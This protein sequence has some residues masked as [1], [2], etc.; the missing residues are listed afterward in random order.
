MDPSR[1][2]L[3]VQRIEPGMAD[4][5]EAFYRDYHE[6][7]ADHYDGLREGGIDVE[8]A[9]V[10]R[11]DDGAFLY[12]YFEADD[13]AAMLAEWRAEDK[14]MDRAFIEEAIVGGIDAYHAETV[15]AVLHVDVPEA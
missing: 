3:S 7:Q 4:A 8:S 12:Y 13:P 2:I 11:T 15:P 6:E 5:V 14:W 1:V 10:H 9:F